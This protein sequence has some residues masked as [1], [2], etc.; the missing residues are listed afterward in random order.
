MCV[1]RVDVFLSCLLSL[2]DLCLPFCNHDVGLQSVKPSEWE[3]RATRYCRCFSSPRRENL[4][5]IWE[6]LWRKWKF[7]H[8]LV[9]EGKIIWMRI[10]SIMDQPIERAAQKGWNLDNGLHWWGWDLGF[11]WAALHV[12]RTGLH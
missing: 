11:S 8:V 12:V 9:P 5:F 1:L 10:T 6:P 2:L 7:Q 4:T 3:L